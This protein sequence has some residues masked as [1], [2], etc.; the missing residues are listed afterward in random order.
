M[1]E[2]SLMTLEGVQPDPRV[3]QMVADAAGLLED[4]NLAPDDWDGALS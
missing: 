1:T 2:H 4:D 3:T